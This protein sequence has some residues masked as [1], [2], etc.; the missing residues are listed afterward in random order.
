[1][2][3]SSSDDFAAQIVQNY[4]HV[5]RNPC[6]S[7]P[8]RAYI[9]IYIEIEKLHMRE[10]IKI[11]WLILPLMAQPCLDGDTILFNLYC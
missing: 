8:E 4:P 5:L 11:N 6:G 1:V 7:V 9:Y 3:D 2:D 10:C